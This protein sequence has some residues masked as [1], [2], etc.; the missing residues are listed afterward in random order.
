MAAL[1]L[2]KDFYITGTISIAERSSLSIWIIDKVDDLVCRMILLAIKRMMMI[3][4]L[5]NDA[6][7]NNSPL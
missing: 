7:V 2:F 3:T 6:S 4:P 1:Y 5:V